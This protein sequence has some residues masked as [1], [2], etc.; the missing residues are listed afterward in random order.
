MIPEL[1]TY[2]LTLEMIGAAGCTGAMLTLS[3]ARQMS[4]PVR[5]VPLF[6]RERV[7]KL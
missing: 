7:G 2:P 4:L 6:M 5:G 1:T 3:K